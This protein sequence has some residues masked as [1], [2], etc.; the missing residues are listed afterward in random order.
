M[1]A[2]KP[3]FEGSVVVQMNCADGTHMPHLRRYLSWTHAKVLV[4]DDVLNHLIQ[5]WS[6][7]FLHIAIPQVGKHGNNIHDL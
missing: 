5:P 4:D 7:P 1:L 3:R 2:G 6:R